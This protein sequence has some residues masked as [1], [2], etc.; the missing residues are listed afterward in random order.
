MAIHRVL[1]F[2]SIL[3]FM[4]ALSNAYV[5]GYILKNQNETLAQNQTSAT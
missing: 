5:N 1:I 2:L 4:F 3:I